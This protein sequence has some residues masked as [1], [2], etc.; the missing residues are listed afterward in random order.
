MPDLVV[1]EDPDTRLRLVS[2]IDEFNAPTGAALCGGELA[3][4][5]GRMPGASSPE[6][7]NTPYASC[8]MLN[9]RVVRL[10]ETALD[11]ELDTPPLCDTTRTTVSALRIGEHVIITLPGEPVTVLA[12]RMRSLLPLG[13]ERMIIIGYAQDHIGYLLTPED[14]LRGG[15]E[16]NITFWGPLEGELIAEQAMALVPLVMTPDREEATADG[17]DRVRVPRVMD[18]IVADPLPATYGAPSSSPAYLLTRALP[19][20][21]SP[22][23]AA[24]VRRLESVFFTWIGA[25]P[26]YGT[27]TVVLEQESPSGT[28]NVVTRRS[29]RPVADGHILVTW[30][31][32]PLNP[33]PGATRVHYWTAEWQA[34]HWLDDHTAE[35]MRR[36]AGRVGVPLGRY[37]L[38]VIGP[39]A[40]GSAAPLY[41]VASDPFEVVAG[42]V[43]VRGSVAGT[44]LSLDLGYHAPAGYRLLD[45]VAGANGRFPIRGGTVQVSIDGG[46]AIDV[47][48]DDEGRAS[49]TVPASFAEVTIVDRFGNVGTFRR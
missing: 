32:M 9:E 13:P 8:N 37:R 44:T 23:P 40:P 47:A 27:P 1:W 20:V 46:A 6:L 25:D 24:E 38:R 11:V 14:W 48:V 15:Y 35:P 17:V 16:P 29:G 18:D 31:P 42:A 7:R 41:E 49:V 34:V 19:E 39:P 12:E 10:F 43:D 21:P 36:L 2:P 33:E 26:L 28:W 22:Q 30:T 3:V 5:F 4:P 45:P